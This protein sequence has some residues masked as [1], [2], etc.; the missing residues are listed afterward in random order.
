MSGA[1][2][3]PRGFAWEQTERLLPV[4]EVIPRYKKLRGGVDAG[5]PVVLTDGGTRIAVIVGWDLWSLQHERYL[6]AA[7]LS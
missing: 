3:R 1:A 7:A 4:A 2:E 5:I 6:H